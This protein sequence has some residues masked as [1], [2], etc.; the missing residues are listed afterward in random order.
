VVFDALHN[1]KIVLSNFFEIMSCAIESTKLIE[2]KEDK[3]NL[4]KLLLSV[5]MPMISMI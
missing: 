1:N 5:S 2:I 3:I 4:K